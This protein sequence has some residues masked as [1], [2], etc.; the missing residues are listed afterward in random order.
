MRVFSPSVCLA[1]LVLAALQF[2]IP[3]HARAD[4]Y[5]L[6]GLGIDNTQFVGMDDSG[7]VVLYASFFSCGNPAT[8]CYETF[9]GTSFTDTSTAPA[10]T[11]DDGTPCSPTVP[12]GGSVLHGVCNNGRDA[13]T[14]YLTASQVQAGVYAGSSPP[15]LLISGGYGPIFMNSIGNIVFDEEVS[16]EWYEAID[17]TTAATPEPGTIVL[18]ATSILALL[19]FARR[20][21]IPQN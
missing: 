16:D 19:A 4:T 18:L 3:T 14:G 10:Y 11:Y 20:R 9:N 2:A 17:L 6:V 12:S 21:P 8:G 7:H 5:D 13:F 15:T 1:A